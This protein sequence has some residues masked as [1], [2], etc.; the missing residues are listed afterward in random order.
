MR[1][2]GQGPKRS[3]SNPQHPQPIQQPDAVLEESV[4]E[5]DCLFQKSV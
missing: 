4:A 5:R 2:R 1:V 3:T